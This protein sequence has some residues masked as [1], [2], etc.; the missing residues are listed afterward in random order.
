[1]STTTDLITGLQGRVCIIYSSK[2]GNTRQVAEALTAATNF[3]LFAVQEAPNIAAYPILALGFWV[4]RAWP[5]DLMLNFMQGITAKQ[6]FFFCTHAAWPESEHIQRC[7]DNVSNLL[8]KNKNKIL[9]CFT[10]Q[11]KVPEDSSGNISLHHPLTEERLHRLQEAKKHPN[12]E[13]CLQA[14][15][16]FRKALSLVQ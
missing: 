11:G 5:D 2:T 3:P 16:S 1:M 7:R 6:I 12:Q 13:D 10:C 9:G 14:V 8:E 15:E 4:R